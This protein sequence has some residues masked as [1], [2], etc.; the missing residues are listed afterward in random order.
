M[1]KKVELYNSKIIDDILESI[2]DTTIEKNMLISAKIDDMLILKNLNKKQFAK[3]M[4]VDEYTITEWLSGTYDFNESLIS[5]IENKLNV[6][7]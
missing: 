6:E 3:I 2:N 5:E 7:L 1:N 4:N